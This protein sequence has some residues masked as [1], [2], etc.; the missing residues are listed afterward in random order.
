MGANVLTGTLPSVM[1]QTL[2]YIVHFGSELPFK[3][4]NKTSK[5]RF[6]NPYKECFIPFFNRDFQTLIKNVLFLSSTDVGSH[7]YS[8]I[9]V[10]FAC[11]LSVFLEILLYVDIGIATTIPVMWLRRQSEVITLFEWY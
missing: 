11:L 9:S 1:A 2:T 8:L 5:E 10:F 7:V 4:L 6:L 3:V